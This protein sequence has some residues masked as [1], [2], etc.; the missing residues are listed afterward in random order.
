M[1]LKNK[2]TEKLKAELKGIKMVVGALIV[3]LS[4]LFIVCIYGL[5][6]KDNTSTF[7]ALI[8]VALALKEH[9]N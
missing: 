4:T 1:D 2:T 7:I 6:A 9:T 8:V 3:V 5:L